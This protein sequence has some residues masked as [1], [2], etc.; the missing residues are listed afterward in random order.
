MSEATRLAVWAPGATSVAAHIRGSEQALTR[1]DLRT[2]WWQLDRVMPEGTDYSLRVDDGEPRPDPRSRWQPDG[3]HGPSRVL[4][5]SSLSWTDDGW[6][7]VPLGDAVVYEAHVGTFS[8]NGTFKGAIEHLDHLVALGV[9]HLELMPVNEFPG[10]RGWGYDGVD[11][12]APFSGYG[13]PDGLSQLVDAAHNRGLAVL[14]DVVYNHLGPSGNY[15][16]QFGPYFTD[17]HKTLWGEALNFDG[18]SSDEVRRFF[19][20]N[21]L[22]WLRDFHID[23]LR[24]DA[25]HAIVDTTATHFLEQLAAEVHALQAELGRPLVVIAESDSNDPRLVRDV[26]HG[27]YGLDA[28]WS[29]DFHHALHTVLT[30][31]RDGYY[32]DF[33]TLHDLAVALQ[34]G[35][36]YAGDY[37]PFRGRVHGRPLSEPDG[38]RLLGYLQNHDQ[39]GNRARGERSAALVSRGRLMIGAAVVLTAP[40]VPMLFQGEEWAAS[41]PFQYFTDHDAELGRLVSNGRKEEFAA[42]GW[43]PDDVPDPQH[44]ETFSRS[45]LRWREIGE[46]PH[47]DMLDWHRRLIA[48]RRQ[49]PELRDGRLDAVDVR[50]DEDDRWLRFTRGGLTV[51]FNLAD[52]E[53]EVRVP[54]SAEILLA[55]DSA[56][57]VGMDTVTLPPDSVAILGHRSKSQALE[58]LSAREAR[59]CPAPQEAAQRFRGPSPG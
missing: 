55:S 35:Y 25:V 27:G 10:T 2:G 4:D 53:R 24:L 36:R 28:Q 59:R 13:G 6:R 18:P 41:T 1:D 21:A 48:L 5:P 19:I 52:A 22:M 51:A 32:A 37:S 54:I 12:Y 31:E 38:N 8:E 39:T 46:A 9:T 14:L 26:Q 15:L 42:F 49:R 16:P 33:G 47:A 11:L 43:D 7:P 57:R 34:H 58:K 29:D 45:K 40:F 20:E 23:G 44:E 56:I 17:R 30:G 50:Y 3:V